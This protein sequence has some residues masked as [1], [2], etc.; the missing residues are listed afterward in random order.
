M[1]NTT[2][3]CPLCQRQLRVPDSLIGQDLKCPACNHTFAGPSEETPAPIH[4][5]ERAPARRFEDDHRREE[6][7]DRPARRRRDDEED[8]E[9]GRPRRRRRP[10]YAEHRGPL[11]LILGICAWVMAP[12]PCGPVAWFLG[13]HDLKEIRAGR[14]DPEG[15]SHTQIGRILGMTSTLLFLLVILGICLVFGFIILMA[16]LAGR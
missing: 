6:D 9:E 1:S 7:E 11:I 14:M 12:I 4:E 13:N 15:E 16:A 10:Q 2:A 5:Q 3:T 8:A